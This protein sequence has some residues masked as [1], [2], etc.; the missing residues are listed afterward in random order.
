[1]RPSE[2]MRGLKRIV[3][4][5]LCGGYLVYAGQALAQAPAP[6]QLKWN[7]LASCPSSESVLARVRQIAGS[8]RA[9]ATPLRAKATITRPS[10]GVFR[11]R[12]Q[13]ESGDLA[14]VRTIEGKSCKDLAGAAAV[15][16][17]LLLSSEEPLSERD[18][19][20]ASSGGVAAGS[21][22][23]GDRGTA[24]K[25]RTTPPPAATGEK[26]ATSSEPAAPTAPTAPVA[27][28]AP[29]QPDSPSD[30]P[31]PPR[32]WHVLLIAPMGALSVGPLRR[33]SHGLAVAAGVSFDSWHFLADAKLWARQRETVSNLGDEYSVDLN[34]FSLSARGC[35]VFGTGFELAPCAL[36]S[37]HHL[38]V[39]G[40]GPNLAS[41]A[42]A[43]TWAAVGVGM[44]ARV[45][46]AP[47]LGLV[48]GVDAELEFARPEVS[49]SL[50]VTG[51]SQL[52]ANSVERLAP[53][54]ATISVGSQWIF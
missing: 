1:V 14:A 39:S 15:A 28:T 18:L 19:A 52:G 24:P 45:L 54:A 5:L 38:S 4:A 12:L 11:L 27:P 3:A 20:G 9:T 48:A 22:E 50:P 31:G 35:R 46:I 8:T 53:G 17:A 7:A 16:L 2:R 37:V 23:A 51:S 29:T 44:Q 34:R 25:E 21:D 49:F 32:R 26:P 10:E 42:D 33:T 43:A 41:R 47:W 30:E 13:I 6:I 40:S 36:V